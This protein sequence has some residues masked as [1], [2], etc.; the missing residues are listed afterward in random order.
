M[1]VA[2][3]VDGNWLLHRA[4]SIVSKYGSSAPERKVPIQVLQWFCAYAITLKATHGA[5]CFDG[6]LNFRHE[7][8]SGYKASRKSASENQRRESGASKSD[9]TYAT[10]QPTLSLFSLA[11]LP[12]YQNPNLEADD[13][14]S[15]GAFAF[16]RDDE[17]SYKEG[18]LAYIVARDKDL[19]QRVDKHVKVWWPAMSNQPE[20]LY[21]VDK[22]LEV[23]GM[24]PRQFADYQ[25]L[26]GDS[27]DDI[28]A[29]VKS[30]TALE[31]LRTHSSLK[32]YFATKEGAAFF[33]KHGNEILRN[34][35]LVTMAHLA[36]K[37]TEQELL[38]RPTD[39]NDHIIREQYFSVPASLSALR[40]IL[41]PNKKGLF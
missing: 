3:F 17:R 11:Q 5:L 16:T 37:P 1:S 28:P 33:R 30:S 22:V 10:L 18:N 41:A 27:V 8:Y 29:I 40:A 31:L 23:K 35:R 19:L 9:N 20:I 21:D 4:E 36:W 2:M 32:R 34:R 39:V 15:A 25:T 24:R 6:G 13:L 14:V 38:L 12:V 7:I 26:I